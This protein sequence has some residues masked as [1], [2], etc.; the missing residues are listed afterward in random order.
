[1][2]GEMD[3]RSNEEW[4]IEDARLR[5]LDAGRW[6]GMRVGAFLGVPLGM[7]LGAL[8]RAAFAHWGLL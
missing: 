1:M 3:A 2:R 4:L 8:L 6:E 5:A 7:S